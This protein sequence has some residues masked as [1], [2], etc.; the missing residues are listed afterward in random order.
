[1]FLGNDIVDLSFISEKFKENKQRYHNFSLSFTEKERFGKLLEND[2]FFWLIWSMKE[3]LYKSWVKAGYRKR[4][5][6]KQIELGN[7]VPETGV[8]YLT[9]NTDFNNNI[10]VVN[11]YMDQNVIHS[12]SRLKNHNDRIKYGLKKI[13]STEY[14]EQTLEVRKLLFE[15][16]P[17]EIS[18]TAKVV[19]DRF[20][21]PTLLPNNGPIRYDISLSHEGNYVASVCQADFNYLI[22][23]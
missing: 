3:S 17:S 10:Y 9:R 5:N 6:P 18:K 15:L 19:K 4:F 13:T 23:D 12:I 22:T 14:S 11:S 7:I 21:I 8:T 16:I 20:Y 1:M 2:S